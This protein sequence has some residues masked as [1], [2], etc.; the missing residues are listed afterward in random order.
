MWQVGDK[1]S[2]C[3]AF[4]AGYLN[5]LSFYFT[6][7][8]DRNP[9]WIR[10]DLHYSILSV[11]LPTFIGFSQVYLPRSTRVR[12][13]LGFLLLEGIIVTSL[14]NGFLLR[15]ITHPIQSTQTHAISEIISDFRLGGSTLALH[16][17]REQSRVRT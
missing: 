7:Q 15:I 13:F 14:W 10:R 5:G 11:A 6:I 9:F 17:I 16:K 1:Y 4:L 8:H 2:W 12:I 3:L